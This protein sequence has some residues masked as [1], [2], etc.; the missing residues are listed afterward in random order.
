MQVFIF[1]H[2]IIDM[3]ACDTSL[4]VLTCERNSS[5][6]RIDKAPELAFIDDANLLA[7]GDQTL[8]F[9]LL[10]TLVGTSELTH[11]LNSKN[12]YR[13]A[14]VDVSCDFPACRRYCGS[15]F[16]APHRQRT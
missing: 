6:C 4:I 7:S 10:R 3:A 13:C 8:R 2:H 12:K 16:I 9:A 15:H 14:P 1:I 5:V 11:I